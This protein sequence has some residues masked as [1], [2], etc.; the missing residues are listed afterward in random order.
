MSA[1][2]TYIA[3]RDSVLRNDERRQAAAEERRQ[4]NALQG[5]GRSL[6]GGDASGARNALYEAG[7]LDQGMAIDR[8]QRQMDQDARERQGAA[9]I[10]GAQGLR[11]LAPEERWQAYESRVAPYLRQMGVGD[12][13]LGQIT[14]EVMDDASLDSVIMMRGGEVEQPKT[15]QTRTGI[16]ERD[17]RTGAYQE[18]YTVPVDPLEQELIRERIAATR[19]QTSQRNASASASSAR[20]AKTRGGGGNNGGR[21]AAAPTA[22]AARPWERRW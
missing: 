12:D 20:A 3:A 18:R 15:F 13:V 7:M 10:A 9:F 11:R 8:G 19:A 2:D 22:P 16:V 4:R 21:P 5:A 6:A 17:P 14:A 1:F